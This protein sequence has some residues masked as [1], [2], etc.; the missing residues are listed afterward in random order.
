MAALPTEVLADASAVA[1]RAAGLVADRA[2]AAI[3]ARG[4]FVVAFSGG[5]SPGEMLCQLAKADV[6]WTKV[7]VAQVDER[8]APIDSRHRNLTQLRARLVEAVQIPPRQILAMP[9]ERTDIAVAVQD[10]AQRLGEI[11]GVPPVFDLVLLGLGTDGH[12][13]SLVP[14]DAALDVSDADVAVTASYM[15]WRRMTLTVPAINRARGI[16]W[17]VTGAEKSVAVRRLLN[18]DQSIPAG[19]ISCASA[20]L[21]V[22]QAAYGRV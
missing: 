4:R 3:A 19:R 16:V 22:D 1:W 11:A 12:T 21:L 2:R 20:L 7:F 14:G 17:L 18:A 15:G 8:I 5:N 13:A 10:Y 9:V 6:D